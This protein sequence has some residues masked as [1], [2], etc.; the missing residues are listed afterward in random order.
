[1][2]QALQGQGDLGASNYADNVKRALIYMGELMLEIA[3]KIT[4]PGQLLHI[5]GED[6]QPQEVIIGQSF[7]MQQGRA[8]PVD[9]HTADVQ[10]GVVKFYDLTAGKYSVTVA[11]GKSFTTKRE[12]G[13]A[14]I[15]QIIP[16]L[17]PQMAMVLAPEFVEN[18][19]FP[20]AH[21]IAQKMRK[22]L[23][24]ALQDI[25]PKE[26]PNLAQQLQQAQAMIQQL[27]PLAQKNAVDLQRE[28]MRVQGTLQ[29]SQQEQ[30]SQAQRVSETNQVS[31]QKA[32]LAAAASM[33]N[34]QA[35]V[36]AENL[37]SFADALEQRLSDKLDLHM[38]AITTALEHSHE[39]NMARQQQAHDLQ[40]MT[41]EHAQ[42]LAQ[43]RQQGQIDQATAA[44][45]QQAAQA[46]QA[47]Q[48][49]QGPQQP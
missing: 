17:D 2:I 44:A 45:Q 5:L 49:A 37:R 31:L 20:G 42:T 33:A 39:A 28:Q 4:R 24:P 41:L 9:P 8:V 26:G 6:E 3:P 13:A 19:S 22:V 29:R 30:Q 10:Q 43:Q 48:P 18:L 7:Q 38:Q 14:A 25:D 32:E 46:Q 21:G 15:A 40:Q 1:M 34:A 47:Q 16:G 36:D 11:I 23:P 35:K 27:Q 12:E